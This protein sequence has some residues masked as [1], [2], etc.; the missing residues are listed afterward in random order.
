MSLVLSD[1]TKEAK[2]AAEQ[3]VNDKKMSFTDFLASFG[4]NAIGVASPLNIIN[5]PG[6][7]KNFAKALVRQELG[8]EGKVIEPF[9]GGGSVS[10]TLINS[11]I[12]NTAVAG[13]TNPRLLNIHK[14]IRSNPDFKP[15]LKEKLDTLFSLPKSK[16]V[17]Y[18]NSLL[19]NSTTDYLEQAVNDVIVGNYSS[20][21]RIPE[22]PKRISME[23]RIS[24][25]GLLNRV[26]EHKQVLQHTDIELRPWQETVKVAKPGDLVVLDPPYYNTKNYPGG[27]FTGTEELVDTIKELQAGGTHGF[28]FD[29]PEG[30]EKYYKGLDKKVYFPSKRSEAVIGWGNV[31]KVFRKM[32]KE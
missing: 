25:E 21:Y 14:Q 11:G 8:V 10:R 30:I 18:V 23:R 16:Q 5:Y 9:V 29:S 17:E 6:A 31:E 2:E 32:F 15:A 27:K 19:S 3:F 26:D 4:S 24:K 20:T 7:K 28:V 13:D 12:S 1:E 22:H